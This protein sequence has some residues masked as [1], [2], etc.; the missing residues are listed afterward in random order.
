MPFTFSRKKAI[1]SQ[2]T[3]NNTETFNYL[4]L[5]NW[6]NTVDSHLT[7]HSMANC[8]DPRHPRNHLQRW[9]QYYPQSPAAKAMISQSLALRTAIN[10]S[11]AEFQH[12]WHRHRRWSHYPKWN[13]SLI[14]FSEN[15]LPPS[16]ARLVLTSR[17]VTL[18]FLGITFSTDMKWKR[19]YW[20]NCKVCCQERW[21]NGRHFSR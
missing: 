7:I 14:F 6:F 12:Q 13:C 10:S 15:L 9:T 8:E 21:F 17:R 19:F 5:H 11:S 18:R 4:C 16:S 3:F 20:I 2:T 1:N